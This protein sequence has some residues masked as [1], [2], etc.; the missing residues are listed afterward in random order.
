MIFLIFQLLNLE[1][2]FFH[3]THQR[4][5]NLI[6]L[7]IFIQFVLR[8]SFGNKS[9]Q[10]EEVVNEKLKRETASPPVSHLPEKALLKATEVCAIFQINFS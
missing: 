4:L 7:C 1:I 2:F 5:S 3:Q 10:L 9:E 6:S 8:R